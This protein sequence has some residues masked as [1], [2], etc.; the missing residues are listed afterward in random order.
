M[1]L[2]FEF[3]VIFGVVGSAFLV[4]TT[5][6]SVIGTVTSEMSDDAFLL[7]EFIGTLTGIGV[8]PFFLK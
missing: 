3:K 8:M 1:T 6:G 2:V 4:V 5:S 7:L